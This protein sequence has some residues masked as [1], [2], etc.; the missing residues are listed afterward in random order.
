MMRALYVGTDTQNRPFS[1]TADRAVQSTSEPGVLDLV[2][3][4]GELTLKDGTWIAIKAD[5]GRYND[6]TGKLLLLGN[7]N[8][9]HDKGYEFKS[10]EAHVDVKAGNAWGDLP[11]TGQGPFGEIFSRGFRLF[12]SGATIVFNGPAHLDLAAGLTGIRRSGGAVQAPATGRSRSSE[13][14]EP[15][16]SRNSRSAAHRGGTPGARAVPTG[17]GPAM[18]TRFRNAAIAPVLAALTA[19]MLQTAPALAQVPGAGSGQGLPIAV[20]AD[21]AIEWHQE[22]KA[23]V[24]RGNAVAKR[25]DVTITGDTLVA[26]YRDIPA[27]GTEIFRLA[28]DGKVH[29]FSPTQNVYGDR[30]VYDVDKLVAVV[31]GSNLKLITPTDVVTARDSLEYWE[32]QKLAVARGDAVAV[33]EQNRVNAD[34]LV[35]L[36]A[37]GADG[38]MEMTRIDAQGNVVITTPT[39]VA[40]GR[41]GVYNLKTEIATLTG[42]VRLTRG[43][44]HLNGQTAEVNMKT[45]ISRLLSTGDRTGGRV[46][47]LFIPG[48]QPGG[49]AQPAPA[50]PRHRPAGTRR[51]HELSI[52]E[53]KRMDRS[54]SR[55]RR[56]RSPR[57]AGGPAP[58]LIAD[59]QGLT[60]SNLGK[61]YKKRPVLR[62]VSVTVQ[63]GEAVGL[64]GPNGAGKTTCFYIIT[65]SDLARL[66]HDQPGR[67]GHHRAAH[68]PP[69]AAWDRLSAA[70]SVDLPRAVRR[71]QHPGGA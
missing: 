1:L 30:A 16:K 45:G 44:N 9:F 20:D 69:R 7:A 28:A 59:N 6:K 31:T 48:Q 47:G 42:D 14:S 61:Q 37:D 65:G 24:A 46:K 70:G 19:L 39:D 13:A 67:P 27:G 5:R 40:R 54:D 53:F 43:E 22:Q 52:R 12:D 17:A 11:V 58:R 56:D 3:P 57:P 68:V 35:G 18:K 62:D 64:L 63:R 29:I 71:E 34:V 66:R 50:R 41:Q 38:S 10:D 23:Y 15:A 26:Y 49:G 60:A 21:Q 51:C 32:T 4:Q 2:R 36:F 8:L 33:R 25:G 55:R